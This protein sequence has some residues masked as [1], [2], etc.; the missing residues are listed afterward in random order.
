MTKAD[1]EHFVGKKAVWVFLKDHKEPVLITYTS[2]ISLHK[3]IRISKGEIEGGPLE[4]WHGLERV[5]YDP[6]SVLAFICPR[7]EL[8][9]KTS[10]IFLNLTVGFDDGTSYDVIIAG[11]NR[12]RIV[13]KQLEA[14]V[15]KE[16][17]R[18]GLWLVI[19]QEENKAAHIKYSK[20]IAYL[21]ST[22]MEKKNED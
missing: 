5:S 11:E 3:A 22:V 21:S 6:R 1:K 12:L 10:K 16:P 8:T 13:Y 2:S 20:P 14:M 7:S 15:G 4:I 18:P 19:P 17:E 9:R